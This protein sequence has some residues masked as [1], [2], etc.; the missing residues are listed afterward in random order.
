MKAQYKI[1]ITNLLLCIS[2]IV[3]AQVSQIPFNPYKPEFSQ[4][5]KYENNKLFITHSSG[6]FYQDYSLGYLPIDWGIDGHLWENYGFIG[7]PINDF[8]INGNKIIGLTDNYYPFGHLLI[9]SNDGGKTF[10]EF[11][12]EILNKENLPE[13][14]RITHILQNPNN[15]DEIL[16]FL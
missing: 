3:T 13:G 12:P 2:T 6:V 11:T 5:I 14:I 9:R 8:I 16:I 10:E 1:I 7:Q 4:Q 15:L